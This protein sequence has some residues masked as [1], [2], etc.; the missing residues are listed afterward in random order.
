MLKQRPSS[1]QTQDTSHILMSTFRDLFSQGG[2]R[3]DLIEN[4]TVSKG[5]ENVFHDKY[6]EKLQNV[7]NICIHTDLSKSYHSKIYF[8][9]T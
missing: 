7:S 9:F 3:Q 5:G 2:M 1:S 8:V 4:L 6:V